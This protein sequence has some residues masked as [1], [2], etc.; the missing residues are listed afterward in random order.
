MDI[1][2][3]KI[4]LLKRILNIDNI[5]IIEKINDFINDEFENDLIFNISSDY[6]EET[7]KGIETIIRM[8]GE[9]K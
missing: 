2:E 9:F 4:A 8:V 3:L 7:E 5:E 6:N 1:Q